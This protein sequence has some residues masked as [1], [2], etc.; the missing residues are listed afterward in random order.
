MLVTTPA[1]VIS[2]L[3]YG[4]AD[5]IVKAYTYSDG[6]KTYMLKGVLKSKKGKFK[7]SHFQ[8]L[9]QLEIVAN[10]RNQGR[11][12]YLKD[13]KVLYS[14]TSLH[15]N[16]K[17]SS[18]LIF[19]AEVLKN[20]IREEEAN[21]QLFNYLE[22]SLIWLD[23]HDKFANF[24]LLVL[25]NLTRY[26][27]FYPDVTAKEHTYFNLLD[28]VFEMKSINKYCIEGRNVE[29]LRQFLGTNFDALNELKLNQHGRSNFLDMMLLY[30]E[31]HIEGFK[32]P[33]SLAILNEIF[34]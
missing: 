21:P 14:Y 28:G 1:I 8:L 5:L 30:Y 24:H 2:A 17:K 22:S 10:H 31:L 29:I 13:I 34:S 27:G 3:K 32:K 18:I 7:A 6:L 26:L 12:E 16:I 33:N 15:T 25:L 20:A 9:T 23:L 4:E 19:I 11:M